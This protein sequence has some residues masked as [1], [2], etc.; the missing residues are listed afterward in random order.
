MKTSEQ[1]TNISKAL[2]ESHKKISHAI[3]DA[4]NP[5]FKNDYAT[6]ESVIDASKSSLLENGIIV[7]QSIGNSSLTTR[8]Q[9]VSGEFIESEIELLVDKNNMQGLGSAITYARRYSLAAMLNISQAD[10]DGNKASENPPQQKQVPKSEYKK[11]ENTSPNDYIIQ[12]GKNKMT[13]TRL[14]DHTF[15]YLNKCVNDTIKWH[16]DNNKTMHS[17][18]QEFVNRATEYLKSQPNFNSDESI[19]F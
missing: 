4:K 8:L 17:N 19:P 9:H 18:T 2:V 5:H 16:K 14:Q 15:D 1:L 3:K 6:L 7:I 12:L 11:T 13:G 10:D